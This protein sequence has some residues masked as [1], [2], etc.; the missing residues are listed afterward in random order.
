M[1]ALRITN[2]RDEQ[3]ESD[4]AP[5]SEI[6]HPPLGSEGQREPGL[7]PEGAKA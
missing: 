6:A 3:D 5:Q 7:L 4:A 2:T 1:V